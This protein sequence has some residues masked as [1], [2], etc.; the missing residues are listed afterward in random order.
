M[1]AGGKSADTMAQSTGYGMD[2][3][4]LLNCLRAYAQ[5]AQGS[6]GDWSTMPDSVARFQQVMKSAICLIYDQQDDIS[7]KER[8]IKFLQANMDRNYNCIK[9]VQGFPERVKS[10][11]HKLGITQVELARRAF[12][13][14]GMVHQ[15][16]MGKRLP[17]RSC[18]RSLAEALG[19]TVEWLAGEEEQHEE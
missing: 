3:T 12:L 8:T 5:W 15:Y 16:E 13:S 17:S 18:L 10:R 9:D 19:C 6:S 2:R 11:R 4:E 14:K 7:K 1:K